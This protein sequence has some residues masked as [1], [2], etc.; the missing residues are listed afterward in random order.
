[1]RDNSL[2]L[3]TDGSR[4]QSTQQAG[5]AFVVIQPDSCVSDIKKPYGRS[6]RKAWGCLAN[7]N[8][9][10]SELV[11]ILK[12]LTWLN[13]RKENEDAVLYT[14][15]EVCMGGLLNWYPRWMRNNF[16][17][18]TGD[19]K[20]K[21]LWT[22]AYY[23]YVACISRRSLIFCHI[24]GHQGV[25]WNTFVDQLA[26][27]ALLWPYVTMP[28]QEEVQAIAQKDLDGLVKKQARMA[29]AHS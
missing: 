26:K 4:Q 24:N 27:N 6:I 7:A 25:Y 12:S 22:D 9:F 14:D 5:W 8:S 28:T 16:Q 11:A 20:H 23:A 19:L 10:H 17:T 2:H 21:N 29:A 13:N 18:L 15:S 1:M 3:Y